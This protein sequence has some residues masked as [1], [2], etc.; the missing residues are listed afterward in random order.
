[1]GNINNNQTSNFIKSVALLTYSHSSYKDVLDIYFLQLTKCFPQIN[2]YLL[3]DKLHSIIPS[4]HKVIHYDD[5]T[6]YYKHILNALKII[7]EDYIIYMQDDFILFDEPNLN[8]LNQCLTK[9]S[10]N[11][12]DFIR[13]IRSGDMNNLTT[14]SFHEI[15]ENSKSLF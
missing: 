8:I 6:Y 12:I 15:P 13:L 1:M 9:I 3:I 7:E 4:N 11:N 2:G 10:L 5:D 14:E